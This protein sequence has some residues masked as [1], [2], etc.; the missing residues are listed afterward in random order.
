MSNIKYLSDTNIF[1]KLYHA[2]LDS[3]ELCEEY[4]KKYT[5]LGF[6]EPVH[7]EIKRTPNVNYDKKASIIDLYDQLSNQYEIVY[8]SKLDSITKQAYIREMNN[9]GYLDYTGKTKA[10]DDIGEKATLLISHLLEI[11]IIHTDDYKFIE[12]VEENRNKY[13]DAELITLN[14][15]LQNLIPEDKKRIK[16]NRDIEMNDSYYNN[17]VVEE[18]EMDRKLKQLINTYSKSR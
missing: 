17:K 10:E 13:P 1:I 2:Y 6:V 7:H 14:T 5:L 12:Y 9:L 16:V 11:P 4:V 18:K 15:V 8:I 3:T